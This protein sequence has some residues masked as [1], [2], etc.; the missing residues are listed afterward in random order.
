V[1][2]DGQVEVAIGVDVGRRHV[3]QRHRARA[4]H[5]RR[6]RQFGERPA[7]LPG[8][9]H[10]PPTERRHQVGTVVAVQVA[11]GQAS[12]VRAAERVRRHGDVLGDPPGPSPVAPHDEERGGGDGGV[13]A[14]GE[15]ARRHGHAGR[16]PGDDVGVAVTV[17]VDERHLVEVHELG[18]SGDDDRAGH[19]ARPVTEVDVDGRIPEHHDVH[20][21]VAVDV[22]GGQTVGVVEVARVRDDRLR[23]EAAGAVAEVDGQIL[24]DA[25]AVDVL[26]HPHQVEGPVLVEVAERHL[27]GH[28]QDVVVDRAVNRREPVGT[29][30]D[31]HRVLG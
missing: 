29:V 18:R 6:D 4:V 25:A 24:V 14:V 8:S 9:D 3:R 23:R 22:T 2:H 21:P 27:L 12:G 26:E 20:V 10:D 5:R 28:G 19:A 17:D 1:T 15:P 16:G 30:V 31:E 7:R 13:A 11:D